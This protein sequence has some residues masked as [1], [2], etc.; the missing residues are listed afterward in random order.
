MNP[1]ENTALKGFCG[2]EVNG[3]N[4]AISYS[5]NSGTKVLTVTD[6]S[7]FS[8][9]DS[10]KN[11]NVWAID[12]KGNEVK[13]RITAAAGNTTLNL[14]TGG[15]VVGSGFTITATVVSTKRAVADLSVRG[16]GLA[17]T[18][19]AGSLGNVDIEIDSLT[20]KE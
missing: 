17:L 14:S 15:F 9:G 12:S 7:V 4:P 13:G 18:A 1:F 10:F 2:C 5:L 19:S 3:F 20:D 6:A 8:A 16:V 11:V